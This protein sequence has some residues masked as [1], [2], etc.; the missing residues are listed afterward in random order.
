MSMSAITMN[1]HQLHF[2]MTQVPFNLIAPIALQVIS[3]LGIL[4]SMSSGMLRYRPN[5]MLML[6]HSKLSINLNLAQ[7]HCQKLAAMRSWTTY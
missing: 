6:W 1:D 3:T 2:M 4:T 5:S 7:I